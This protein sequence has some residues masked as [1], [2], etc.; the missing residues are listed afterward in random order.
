VRSIGF[1]IGLDTAYHI[2]AGVASPVNPDHFKVENAKER[3]RLSFRSPDALRSD[4]ELLNVPA[5]EPIMRWFLFG[6]ADPVH[7]R[8]RY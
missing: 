5:V 3:Q 1:Q 8:K 6:C 4:V 7:A 2:Q